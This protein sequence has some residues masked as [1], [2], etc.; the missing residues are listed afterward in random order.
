MSNEK[1]GNLMSGVRNVWGRDY[2]KALEFMRKIYISNSS[3]ILS[4]AENSLRE[5]I[6][7][8]D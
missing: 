7:H 4:R 5:C 2:V 6:L 3:H 1:K 8:F